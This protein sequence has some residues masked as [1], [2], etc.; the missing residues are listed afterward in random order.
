MSQEY[1]RAHLKHLGVP[2]YSPDIELDIEIDEEEPYE[3]EPLPDDH[4]CC[5][6]TALR[7]DSGVPYCFL[8]RCD[9]E[10]FKLSEDDE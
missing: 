8:P 1:L 10:I 4:P 2:T 6:C 3:M 9:K 7:T 5:D